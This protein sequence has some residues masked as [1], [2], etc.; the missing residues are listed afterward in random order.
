MEKP[1]W[2][3]K[4]VWFNLVTAVLA[5]LA[6]PEFVHLV[7]TSWLPYIGLVSAIGNTVLRSVSTQPLGS[8]FKR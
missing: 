1:F 3:S 2:Q 7:P 8:P 5:V 6:L 4:T